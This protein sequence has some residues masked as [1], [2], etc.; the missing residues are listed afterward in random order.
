MSHF[1][2][3]FTCMELF[4]PDLTVSFHDIFRPI[5]CGYG[6][7]VS[8][9]YWCWTRKGALYFLAWFYTHNNLTSVFNRSVSHEQTLGPTSNLSTHAPEAMNNV[10]SRCSAQGEDMYLAQGHCS[11]EWQ[12]NATQ[13]LPTFSC[14]VAFLVSVNQCCPS[15]RSFAKYH[16]H[17]AATATLAA[18]SAALILPEIVTFLMKYTACSFFFF[19][20]YCYLTEHNGFI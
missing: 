7:S 5:G 20:F 13:S 1:H 19:C 10:H 4:H 14:R 17:S 15:F 3:V 12:W 11:C 16:D 2:T 18:I 8:L 6:W 9:Y